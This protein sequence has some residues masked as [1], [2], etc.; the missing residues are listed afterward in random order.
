MYQYDKFQVGLFS[1]LDY[2][3]QS[4]NVIWAYQGKPWVGFAIGV[5]LFGENKSSNTTSQTQE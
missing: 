4:S 3:D 5:S 2:I 1:G